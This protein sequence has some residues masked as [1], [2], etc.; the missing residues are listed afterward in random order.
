MSFSSFFQHLMSRQVKRQVKRASR[1][2]RPFLE[3]LEDR[4]VL[5]F[6]RRA[7]DQALQ[8]KTRKARALHQLI[9]FHD[10]VLVMPA[11]VE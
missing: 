5:C 11:V 4:C 8:R 10:M 3:A 7:H 9:E 1:S 6:P 2:A